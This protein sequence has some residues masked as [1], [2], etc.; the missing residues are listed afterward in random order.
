MA[1]VTV[2]AVPLMCSIAPR[3]PLQSAAD[4][5]K[6]APFPDFAPLRL[7]N[8]F[9]LHF[10]LHQSFFV[11][12]LIWLDLLEVKSISSS[13]VEVVAASAQE[14]LYGMAFRCPMA[15]LESVDSFV[16]PVFLRRYQVVEAEQVSL[17]ELHRLQ[18]C[19]Q[20]QSF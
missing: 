13:A 15:I 18:R 19:H 6:F 5:L 8:Y 20:I 9:C 7:L 12:R 14:I 3:H 4:M 10:V 16:L 17:N 1:P 2:L 11:D